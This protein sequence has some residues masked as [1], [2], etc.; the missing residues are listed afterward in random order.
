MTD[1]MILMTMTDERKRQ[2]T[3]HPDQHPPQMHR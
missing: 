2:R 1:E 3:K